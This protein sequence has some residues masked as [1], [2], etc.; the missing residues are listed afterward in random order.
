MQAHSRQHFLDFVQGLAA[1]I[2]GPEHI[3]LGLLH[4]IADIDDVIVLQAIGRADTKLE[5]I[6]LAQQIA[7]ERQFVAAFLGDLALRLLEVDEQLQLV[8]QNAGRQRD[9][10]IRRHRAVGLDVDIELIVVGRLADAGIFDLV[11]DAAD[12]RKDG[13]DRYQADRAIFSAV[14]SGGDIALA[15]LDRHFHL[16]RRA[17]V[18]MAQHQIGVHDLDIGTGLDHAGL[19]LA[20]PLGLQGHPLRTLGHHLQAHRFE[21]EHDVGDVLAD[22]R[23]RR[24]FV[25]NA[26]DLDRR[27][28]RAVQRRQQDTPQRVAES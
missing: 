16:E 4:Q 10:I 13:V 27:H 7:V 24:K 1:E 8:L 22:P 9:R 28:R 14:L 11:G 6:D 5:F 2:G 3:R 12:R 19:D 20:R 26:L 15:V 17:L 21:I 18:E 25:Q 23:N